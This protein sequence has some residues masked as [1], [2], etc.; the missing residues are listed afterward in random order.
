MLWSG[1]VEL[2]QESQFSV[3]D[4]VESIRQVDGHNGGA[5]LFCLVIEEGKD[6]YKSDPSEFSYEDL[7]KFTSSSN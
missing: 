5:F 6:G 4:H 2:R 3:V 7:K 1:L